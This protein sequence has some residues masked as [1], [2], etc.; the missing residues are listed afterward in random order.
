M[1]GN[2]LSIM[3]NA[4]SFS[5]FVVFYLYFQK[6]Y[7]G[8]WDEVKM[9]YDLRADAIPIKTA[10]ASREIASDVSAK[11][12]LSHAPRRALPCQLLLMVT[13]ALPPVQIQAGAREAEGTLRGRA[14]RKGRFQNPVCPGRS[15]SSERTRVQ[16]ALCQAED[17][18]PPASGHDVHCPSQAGADPGE[19][20]RLPAL[21]APV[22]LPP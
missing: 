21:P 10:K 18:V 5:M 2:F 14:G 16:E 1:S 7:K 11:R 15:Q 9:S 17:P 19:R 20:R 22:D 6:Q 3:T 13:S 12:G 8:A 4:R